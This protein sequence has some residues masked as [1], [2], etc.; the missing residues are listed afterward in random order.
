MSGPSHSYT[1]LVVDSLNDLAGSSEVL[2]SMLGTIAS[3]L[4]EDIAQLKQL[5]ATEQLPQVASKL[6]TF[7]GYIPMMCQPAMAERLISV[8]ALARDQNTRALWGSNQ[9]SRLLQD[10]DT[11]H[12]EIQAAADGQG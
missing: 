7:K 6:H 9:L 12:Q 1:L 10:L 4:K 3:T 2:A 5:A 11:L 8:E